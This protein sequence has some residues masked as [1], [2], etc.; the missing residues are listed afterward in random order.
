MS[1]SP[2]NKNVSLPAPETP[3]SL[4][5]VYSAKPK[6]FRL[7]GGGGERGRHANFCLLVAVGR[8]RPL[9]LVDGGKRA[10]DKNVP[11]VA[12]ILDV[13][14]LCASRFRS[15]Q[16]IEPGGFGDGDY[17]SGRRT[18]HGR[19]ALR[20]RG[21]LAQAQ[22]RPRSKR[23]R[24]GR[25]AEQRDSAQHR[26]GDQLLPIFRSQFHSSAPQITVKHD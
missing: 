5:P 4:H 15:V 2:S 25:P 13:P 24:T 12:G 1:P 10:S 6:N 9:G 7:I 18:P 21:R 11:A 16:Q 19:D 23:A 8:L 3:A 20:L 26:E 17:L 22:T 14:P